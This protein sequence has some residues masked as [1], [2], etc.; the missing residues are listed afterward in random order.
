MKDFEEA[1][2]YD[3]VS[4]VPIHTSIESRKT[5]NTSTEIGSQIL[6]IP[7]I[8]APMNTVTEREM[9]ETMASIGAD[10]VLHRYMSIDDQCNQFRKVKASYKPW[11][12]VGQNGIFMDRA[13][14]LY[15]KGARKFCIDVANGHAQMCL[16]AT[17]AL[18]DKFGDDIDIMAGNVCTGEGAY[19]LEK[20][21]AN[22]IRVGVGCGAVC[23]TRLVTGFGI[24]QLSA[25]KWCSEAV[26]YAQI[27]ADGGIRN[28]GDCVKALVFADALMIGGLLAGSD[29][30][31]GET[32]V[33]SETKRLYKYYFGMASSEGRSKYMSQ[34]SSDFVPEG[35]ATKVWH[36]GD[37]TKIIESLNNGI[38]V[39]MTFANAR[40]LSELRQ[41]A[42]F[43]KI[44]HN[45]QIEAQI[46]KRM[47]K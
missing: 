35:G 36:K 25:I 42:K 13:I 1:L 18:R 32:K 22:V 5:P 38:K 24:P 30:T 40:N 14:A 28:S 26:E 46:N 27:V 8:S 34:E 45:G 41:N 37:T 7:I 16:D 29:S 47:F 21:G 15:K 4:L 3:D 19:D 10:S 9:C 39:G 6:K 23:S 17:K 2:S 20:A 44:T 12:A 33:D 31:P 43:V 11:V